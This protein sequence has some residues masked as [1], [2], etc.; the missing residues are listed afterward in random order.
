MV[1]TMNRNSIRWRLPASYAVI[2]LV[3]AL[4]LGSF[5]LLALRSY[6][7]D[8]EH[9]YLLGNAIALQPDG[10]PGP[11]TQFWES[12]PADG[13]GPA[14]PGELDLQVVDRQQRGGRPRSIA[15][16]RRGFG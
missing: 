9:T 5:M 8:Q 14:A 16:D 10:R 11:M 7:A 13:P 1:M 4:S 6:Y 12:R 3:A 15:D 2:A